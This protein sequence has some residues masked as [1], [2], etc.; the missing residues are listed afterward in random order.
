MQNILFAWM[1]QENHSELLTNYSPQITFYLT[2]SPYISVNEVLMRAFISFK[3]ILDG[4]TRCLQ[5]DASILTFALLHMQNRLG[6]MKIRGQQKFFL[7]SLCSGG[8]GSRIL[9]GN[10]DSKQKI[11]SFLIFVFLIQAQ[12]VILTLITK[13]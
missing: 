2:P 10:S 3:R 6:A 7:G 5:L 1:I 9:Y 12:T 8:T 11:L 13:C 4:C